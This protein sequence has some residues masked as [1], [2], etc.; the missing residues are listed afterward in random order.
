MN[1]SSNKEQE[2]KGIEGQFWK[3][4][5]SSRYHIKSNTKYEVGGEEIEY[6]SEDEG[7]MDDLEEE[8]GV[9]LEDDWE[10]DAGLHGYQFWNESELESDG[11]EDVCPPNA[12]HFIK[13]STKRK[14]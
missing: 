8:S 10:H 14:S 1:S 3:R 2:T 9:N 12:H 7:D 5:R 11:V 4:T 13:V 6:L